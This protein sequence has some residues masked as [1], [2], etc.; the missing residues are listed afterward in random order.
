MMGVYLAGPVEDQ[1]DDIE[2]WR[3]DLV[4]GDR[5]FKWLD[6][7]GTIDNL[8][9]PDDELLVDVC[10]QLLRNADGVLVNWQ[11]V[12]T[13]GTPVEMYEANRIE[14]PIVVAYDGDDEDIPTFIR[15]F[16][17]ETVDDVPTAADVL[18]DRLDP[19]IPDSL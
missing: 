10:L 6:P 19:E 15:A 16:A 3:A 7:V 14:L 18:V 4:A 13:A 2:G 5:R 17:D 8:V 12:T 1:S 11:N 9:E